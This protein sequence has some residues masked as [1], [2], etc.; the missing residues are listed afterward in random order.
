MTTAKLQLQARGPYRVIG[1]APDSEDS[2]ILQKLAGD[3]RLVR[4]YQPRTINEA[5]IRIEKLPSQIVMHKQVETPNTRLAQAQQIR[6]RNPL[7]KILGIPEFGTYQQAAPTE[8]YA[9][10]KIRD[11]WDKEID[12]TSDTESIETEVQQAIAASEEIETLEPVQAENK[13][14]IANAEKPATRD[15]RAKRPRVQLEIN[16]I[17]QEA[18]TGRTI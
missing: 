15:K 18:Q 8:E 3:Q 7:E 11:L 1:Q 13:N 4:N 2:Y 16:Q 5:S 10:V 17:P 14:G 9:F 6:S 12:D